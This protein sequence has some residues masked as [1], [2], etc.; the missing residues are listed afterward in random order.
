MGK[1]K[2]TRQ[3]HAHL[4]V[5]DEAGSLVHSERHDVGDVDAYASDLHALS[6]AHRIEGDNNVAP[7]GSAWTSTQAESTDDADELTPE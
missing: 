6:E 2:A 4:V 1:K 5:R 7:A 3:G